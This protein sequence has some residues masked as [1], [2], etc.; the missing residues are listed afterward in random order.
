MIMLCCTKAL[1]PG[2]PR[3]GKLGDNFVLPRTIH[4]PSLLGA[5]VGAM[6]FGVGSLA[7][8]AP[9]LGAATAGM[10]GTAV[11]VLMGIMIVQ[12]RPWSGEHIGRVAIVRMFALTSTVSAVC[13]GSGRLARYDIDSGQNLCSRCGLVVEPRD[14]LT[15][16]HKWRRRLYVGIAPVGE[17]I[18]GPVRFVPGSTEVP[19]VEQRGQKIAA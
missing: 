16:S 7:M 4:V 2:L 17:P 19:A 18:T 15:P 14:E 1:R 3:I 5:F 6:I 9:A 8:L 13:P 12:W 10:G 11:G